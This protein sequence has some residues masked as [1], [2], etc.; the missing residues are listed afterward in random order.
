MT[1]AMSRPAGAPSTEAVMMC[2]AL[3]AGRPAYT[4]ITPVAIVEK[5]VTMS[6]MSSLF[7]IFGR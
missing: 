7:V 6:A 4:T 5:P 2:P 1:F 3:I